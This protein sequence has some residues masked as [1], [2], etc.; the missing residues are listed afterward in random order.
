MLAILQLY[1]LHG[2][3]PLIILRDEAK[4]PQIILK[5]V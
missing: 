4:S 1:N 3:S 5:L 2:A